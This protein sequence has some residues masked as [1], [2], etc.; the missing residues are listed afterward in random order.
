MQCALRLI[1]AASRLRSIA[2]AMPALELRGSGSK[3]H[4]LQPKTSQL[5]L[6]FNITFL[7][8]VHC[9]M[10][11]WPVVIDILKT[12]KDTCALSQYPT[13]MLGRTCKT[14]KC[15]SFRKPC[16]QSS[17][18]LSL[19]LLFLQF[20]TGHSCWPIATYLQVVEMF[21]AHGNA[22]PHANGYGWSPAHLSSVSEVYFYNRSKT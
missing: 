20:W 3:H 14:R 15:Q 10:W 9:I 21:L 22:V 1:D 5:Y 19:I 12:I 7:T 8:A 2:I 4:H 18:T 16:P 17:L 6:I 13:F 11:T